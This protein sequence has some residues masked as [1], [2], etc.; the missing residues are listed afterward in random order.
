MGD[1]SNPL[2][3][4]HAFSS[5]FREQLSTSELICDIGEGMDQKQAILSNKVR[6]AFEPKGDKSLNML[7]YAQF[8]PNFSLS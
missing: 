5:C 6:P 4:H 7:N 1:G 2:N 3:I 8:I